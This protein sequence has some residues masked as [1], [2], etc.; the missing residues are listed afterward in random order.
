MNPHGSGPGSG[1]KN[2]RNREAG[3]LGTSSNNYGTGNMGPSS[4]SKH[5]EWDNDQ[6][7]VGQNANFT[8][9][10]EDENNIHIMNVG[11]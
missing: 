2:I 11:G 5:Y 10:I 6:P 8:K 3:T 4:G 9:D 1:M 7:N